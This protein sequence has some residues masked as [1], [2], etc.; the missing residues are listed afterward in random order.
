VSADRLHGLP[1]IVLLAVAN[2]VLAAWQ[3][4]D[5][6]HAAELRRARMVAEQNLHQAERKMVACVESRPFT[7]G[8]AIY[9]PETRLG[10]LTVAHVPEAAGL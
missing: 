4:F 10:E 8:S 5:I 3:M 1:L 7:I 9:F 2:G 6:H